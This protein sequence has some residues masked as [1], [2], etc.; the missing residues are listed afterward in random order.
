[1]PVLLM[2]WGIQPGEFLTRVTPADI[3]PTLAAL[4][5]I[6]LAASDGHA[7]AE[8]LKAPQARRPATAKH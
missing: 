1:V 4:C 6:T 8:A 5:G 3:A 7:L 2:G